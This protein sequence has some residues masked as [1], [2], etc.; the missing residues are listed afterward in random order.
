M[1]GKN[2]IAVSGTPKKGKQEHDEDAGGKSDDCSDLTDN[3][4]E[5]DDM[6]SKSFPQKV[7]SLVLGLVA[8]LSSR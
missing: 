7:S 3:N 2:K 1:P 5:T 6:A 4:H 8:K